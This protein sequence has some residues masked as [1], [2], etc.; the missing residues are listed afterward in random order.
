MTVWLVLSA[1]LHGREASLISR[2]FTKNKWL[3]RRRIKSD[4]GFSVAFG[5]DTLVYRESGRGMAITVDVGANQANLF[6]NS[7]GRWDDDLMNTVKPEEK[8]R[9]ADNIKLVLEWDGLVV[10]LL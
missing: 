8:E 1:Q 2:V 3:H 6:T 7:V 5:R 10:C 9:I 4:E